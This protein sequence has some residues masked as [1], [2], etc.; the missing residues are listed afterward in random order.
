MDAYQRKLKME[1]WLK[2]LLSSIIFPIVG[3]MYITLANRI[4]TKVS[5]ENCDIK[6]GHT[7]R[8]YNRHEKLLKDIYTK[9]NAI[10]VNVAKLAARN[11]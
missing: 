8:D 7:E 2:Y 5:K 3:F 4:S 9:V 11:K 6:H 1:N 10:D